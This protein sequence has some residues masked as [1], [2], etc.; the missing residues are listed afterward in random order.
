MALQRNI[1]AHRAYGC[2]DRRPPCLQ[3]H[4]SLVS[5]VQSQRVA[6]HE[7]SG[8]QRRADECSARYWE[9][10]RGVPAQHLCK[11][12]HDCHS[13]WWRAVLSRGHTGLAAAAAVHAA[14]LGVG[15]VV[16]APVRP[17]APVIQ[18]LHGQRR[19][20]HSR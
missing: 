12:P 13:R 3:T 11:M 17:S 5:K 19:H 10:C 8:W 18:R 2:R 16:A 9:L 14:S 15:A 20:T 6:P 1:A 4:A 7:P